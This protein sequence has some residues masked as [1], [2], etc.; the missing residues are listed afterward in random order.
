MSAEARACAIA[1]VAIN[2]A[3]RPGLNRL[4]TKYRILNTNRLYNCRE[5]STNPPF[6]AK[7]TQ[8]QNP[9]NLHKCK[10]NKEIRKFSGPPAPKKRT[11]TKPIFRLYVLKWAIMG[12]RFFVD[13]GGFLDDNTLSKWP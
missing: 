1:V 5:S 11:Q 7:R 6:Y 9:Q 8:F 4:N 10:Y 3:G 13:I 12:Y 2:N